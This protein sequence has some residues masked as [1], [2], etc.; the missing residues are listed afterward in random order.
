MSTVVVTEA[1][2]L[3]PEEAKS[4]LATFEEEIGSKYGLKVHWNGLKAALKG[5]GASG[6]VDVTSSAVTITVKLGMV[7][8]MAGVKAEMV[9]ASVKKRLKAALTG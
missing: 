5:V 9:E 8:R 4:R 3:A 7:A 6:D 1:H 2:S